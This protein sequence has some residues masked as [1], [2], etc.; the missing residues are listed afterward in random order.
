V[1]P[2][3]G[4]E[5]VALPDLDALRA[6]ARGEAGPLAR[7]S[8][9]LGGGAP[10]PDLA[11]LSAAE[12]ARLLLHL[13]PR[14][15]RALLR[16]L[17]AAPSLALLHEL[18][19]AVTAR[20]IDPEGAARLAEIVSR[21]DDDRA[22][23]FL[24]EA[25]PAV[26]EAALA[27][28]PR[29]GALRAALRHRAGTAG[30]VMRRRLVAAPEDWTLGRLVEEIRANS[31][32][33]DRLHAVY[34]IDGE[35]RLTGYL[36][37]RD[38][39]L[40]PLDARVGAIRRTDV[41]AV[42]AE[43]DRAEVAEIARREHLPALP[44]VDAE[45]RLLGIVR[46]EELRA[47]DR[48]EADED[49]A[50]MAG[51]DP[52]ATA[53]DGPLQIVR[54]RLPW[55]AGGLVGAGTAAVVVGAYEDALTE[56]AILAS[57]IPIVMSLAGN[58]GIQASTVTVQAMTAGRLWLGDLAGRTLREIGGALL[59]G[60]LV[61]LITA[62]A[63]LAL[64][65]VVEIERAPALALAAA[66]TLVVVTVQASAIGSLIPILLE[67]LRFDPAV[68]TGVFITTSNDVVGV[69]I[70]FLIATTIYL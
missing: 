46:V 17:D 3:D 67:K 7:V 40:N 10:P 21:L 26:V 64:S 58:A 34:V 47:I 18:D 15:A 69:L 16:A 70:F 48:A 11:R 65:T 25:P 36:K 61:G 39:L 1:S 66:L 55:L 54:R 6:A 37:V 28:S 13:S 29:A 49:L 30:A 9:A 56:A 52:E 42:T 45:G 14:R 24:A 57:L 44:V 2:R 63:I 33:I 4:A 12:A 5:A 32:Q 51:L 35:R 20:L 60:G 19:P 27:H 53:A 41:V 38:L 50:L 8:A 23:D 68:A 62:A 22:A 59:N 31:E 43:T